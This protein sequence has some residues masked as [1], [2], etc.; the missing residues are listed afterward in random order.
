M[1]S[2]QRADGAWANEVSDSREDD[3]LVATP[4]A[5]SALL[6]CRQQLSPR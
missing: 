4:F 2:T 5:A 1:W 3:P 6:I